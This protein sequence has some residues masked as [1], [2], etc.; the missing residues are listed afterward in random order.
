MKRS[1]RASRPSVKAR[2]I[3]RTSV[4]VRSS[5]ALAVCV[6]FAASA[7]AQNGAPAS[8]TNSS[9]SPQIELQHRPEESEASAPAPPTVALAVPKGTP[10]EVALDKELRVKHIGERVRGRLVEPVY[11]FDKLVIPAGSQI[12][13]RVTQ[14]EG[15]SAGRRTESALNADFTP[16]RKIEIEFDDVSLPG[17]KQ[18]PIETKVTP[19]SG[20][21]LNFVSSPTTNEKSTLAGEAAVKTHEAKQTAH[22]QWNAV[23]KQVKAPGKVRRLERYAIRQL[24]AHPQY[25][26]AGTI[27][28]AELQAPLNFGSEPLTLQMARS[29]GDISPTGGVVHARL[30][31]AVT[32]ASNR[33]GDPVNA[34]I[35][36]PLFE[37][38]RLVVPEGSVLEGSV[39]QVRPARRLN[40]NGQ[41]RVAF[42]E[43]RLPDAVPQE[44]EANL[45]SVQ[46]GKS[47][48]VKLDSEGGAQATTPKTR[49]LS[50]AVEIGLAGLAAR[51][52]PDAKTANPSGTTGSRMA[53]GIGGYKLIG[54]LLGA[55]VQS[56][57]FSYSMGAYGAG[58]SV[59]THFI[60]RGRDVVFPKDTAMQIGLGVHDSS[61][62]TPAPQPVR[63]GN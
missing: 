39:V 38:G 60:A 16:S 45:E 26:D 20:Q 63:T 37:N 7:F 29:I 48:N 40:R 3:A 52:D 23:M 30:E 54:A 8:Q 56:R 62:Q 27:Y 55:F 21:L 57:T 36:Q 51:G 46:A 31:M 6:V 53:G 14:I 50:T 32:S 59:Y 1:H 43:L 49:Y 47:A 13:G 61:P 11:A 35:T 34:V 41:L 19:G 24:P 5:L 58:M 17:G 15:V 22:D 9:H 18:L 44:I 33:Q 28:F 25:I 12:T 10:L 4:R 2:Q 42:H